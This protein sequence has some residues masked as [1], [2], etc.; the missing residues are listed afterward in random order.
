MEPVETEVQEHEGA[1]GLVPALPAAAPFVIPP[2]GPPAPVHHPHPPVGAPAHGHLPGPVVVAPLAAPAHVAA[3]APAPAPAP[4][5]TPASLRKYA[6][7]ISGDEL[8]ALAVLPLVLP[9][10]PMA[11]AAPA[12]AVGPPV[13]APAP[14]PPAGPAVVLPDPV[15]PRIMRRRVW[16]LTGA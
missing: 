1:L 2:V 13:A 8:V 10:L 15:D 12:P 14:G 4:A 7:M 9:V 16:H 3:P 11:A 6:K 5:A